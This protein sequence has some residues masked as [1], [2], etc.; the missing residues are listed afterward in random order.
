MS[1]LFE[2][3][4]ASVKL[5]NGRV[6]VYHNINTGLKKFHRFLCEKFESPDR[7]ISYS[8][9]RKANKEIVGKFRNRVPGK[10]EK[11]V[12][13]FSETIENNNK[14]GAFV[15]VIFERNGFDIESILTF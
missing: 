13:I 10:E 2:R 7:W 5:S 4:E 3:Y 14:T 8:V 11:V 6:V 1:S 15:P 12:T 9:R